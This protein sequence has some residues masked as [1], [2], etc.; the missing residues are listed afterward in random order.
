MLAPFSTG[1]AITGMSDCANKASGKLAR[2][3]RAIFQII[4]LTKMSAR[5]AFYAQTPN[6]A[7]KFREKMRNATD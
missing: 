7:A 5:K 1:P 6:N 2:R 4:R 3:R